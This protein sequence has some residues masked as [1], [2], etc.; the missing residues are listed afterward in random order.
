MRF[1][2]T[3]VLALVLV[4]LGTFYYLYEVRWAPEREKAAQVKGRLWSVEAKDVEEAVFRRKAETIHVK[5]EGS[6][7]VLLAPVKAKADR[8]AVEDLVA[9][10]VTAR[11]D[12]EIDPNPVKLGDFGLDAPAVDI[13]VR[14]KG[15]QEALTLLLGEKN[16][17]GVWVYATT[18]AKPAVF[19]LSDF[20]LRDATKPAADFRD[21][22]I[23]TFDRKDVAGLEIAVEGELMAVEP[24]AERKWKITKPVSL[25]ADMDAISDFLDKL[26]FA[27]VKEFVVEAPKSMRPYGLDRPARVTV[28]LGKEKGAHTLLFGKPEPAKQGVYAMRAG[29]PS[30]L[31]VGEDLWT[32]LPKTVGALRD[33]TVLDYDRDK[34]SRLELESPKGKVALAKEGEKWQV[35]APESLKADDGEVGGLL[36]KIREMRAAGFLG[37]G[38]TAVTRYLAKPEVKVSLGEPGAPAAK[39]LLLA[40]SPEKRR[41]K[42]MAYAGVVGQGPVMLVDAQ[43]LGDLSKS[44]SD[45]RDRTVLPFFDPKEVKRM[46]VRSGGQAMVLE[47]KG[48]AEWR[49]TEPKSGKA[50]ENTVT[51]LLYNLRLLRWRELVSPKGDDA[52]RYGLDGS[53]FE[54]TLYRA[55]GK[56]LGRLMVGRKEADKVFVRTGASPAIFAL[57]PKQLGDLPKIPDDLRG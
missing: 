30:V 19:V 3:L 20:V 54:V 39:T 25:R 32:T 42:P 11:V 24:E 55:D 23:L 37:E 44:A 17:T 16:P 6:D 53:S 48:E 33:K 29:D 27:K 12:R 26:R 47:R 14:V 41:G 21:K 8:N 52:A 2:T 4:A 56:E 57:D 31:L 38:P 49:V 43:Y 5:R 46:R 45:L 18:K 22:T 40:P 28:L 50:K 51:D 36:F 15:K 9:N 7:W 35:T 13:T 1:K 10:L 34:V